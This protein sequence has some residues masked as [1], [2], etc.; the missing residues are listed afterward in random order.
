MQVHG[1]TFGLSSHL[2]CAFGCGKR[3]G[4]S[5]ALSKLP[6]KGQHGRSAG[7]SQLRLFLSPVSE[8]SHGN[9]SGRARGHRVGLHS[10][11]GVGNAGISE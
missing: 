7:K 9:R 1:C 2:S 8:L 10:D 4:G 3:S 5:G 11:T 6:P